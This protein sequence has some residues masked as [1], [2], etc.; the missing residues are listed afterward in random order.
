MIRDP[1]N[2]RLWQKKEASTE[3]PY[4]LME[5]GIVFMD[6]CWS[7]LAGAPVLVAVR[8]KVWVCARSP[9]EIMVSNPDGVELLWM[10]DRPEETYRHFCVNVCDL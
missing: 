4:S 1:F 3:V 2:E 10:I 6:I 5:Y 7:Y 9:A 8:S